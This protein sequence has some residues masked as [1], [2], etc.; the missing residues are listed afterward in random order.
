MIRILAPGTAEERLIAEI[1]APLGHKAETYT[2]AAGGEAA[3]PELGIIWWNG[4]TGRDTA[5]KLAEEARRIIVILPAGGNET[6][7]KALGADAFFPAPFRPGQITD[8][9]RTFLNSSAQDRLPAHI[10]LETHDF[11]PRE[12]RVH[13]KKTKQNLKLT[14]KERDIILTLHNA[15]GKAVSRQDLLDAVWAYAPGVET[16]TLET[17]IYRLRQK[18]EADPASPQI[19]LTDE[20]G[21]KI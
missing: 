10:A 13:D 2:P 7:A 16:H 18:I 11:Y 3:L 19:I 8:R 1:V 21:Y 15:G 14:D 20:A 12:N 17:H 6:E 4:K 9:A 5:E